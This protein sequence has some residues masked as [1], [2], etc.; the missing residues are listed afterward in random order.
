MAAPPMT[1]LRGVAVDVAEAGAEDEGLEGV[2]VAGP[3]R[4]EHAELVG[5]EEQRDL[6]GG[7][8]AIK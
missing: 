6:A 1:S 5:R 3:D 2:A 4:H 7:E 8:S